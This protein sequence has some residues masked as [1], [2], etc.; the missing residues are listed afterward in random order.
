M[1]D[2]SIVEL[3]PILICTEQSTIVRTEFQSSHGPIEIPATSF[4]SLWLEDLTLVG[5]GVSSQLPGRAMSLQDYAVYVLHELGNTNSKY[6]AISV[7]VTSFM[8]STQFSVRSAPIVG[9][10]MNANCATFLS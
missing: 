1:E 4:A 5:Q 6:A 8:Q 2:K 10:A 7:P 3:Y 9:S